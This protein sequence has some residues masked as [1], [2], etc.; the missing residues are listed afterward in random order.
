MSRKYT[1]KLIQMMDEGVLTPRQLADACLAYMS[2]ADVEDMAT[3]EG[4]ID[5][6]D[7]D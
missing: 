4:L 2:E 5:D 6:D 7:D 1:R 3:S